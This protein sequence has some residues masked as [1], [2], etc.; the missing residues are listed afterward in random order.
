MPPTQAKKSRALLIGR[1]V[2]DEDLSSVLSGYGYF[3]EHCRTR[4]E[5]V[6]KFRQHRPA[7]VI[8]DMDAVSGLPE[9][10][11]RFFRLVR[12]HSIVLVAADKQQ[13]SLAA[14]YLL[15][16][17]QDVLRLPLR[18]N[19]LNFTL[20]RTSVYHRKM[21]RSSFLRNLFYF[22]IAMTPLWV[23]ALYLALR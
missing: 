22:G 5:G 7:L 12:E 2:L 16:G 19:D 18:H 1:R 15:W 17:A 20:S 4:L 3:V 13:E 11:F 8:V 21:V 23:L 9:R 10:F 6:R 14:R